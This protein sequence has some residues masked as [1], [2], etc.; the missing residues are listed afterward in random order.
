MCSS[1]L[2]F[3]VSPVFSNCLSLSLTD[4]RPFPP[5]SSAVCTSILVL[6]NMLFKLGSYSLQ[7]LVPPNQCTSPSLLFPF[8]RILQNP[9]PW[10]DLGPPS[11]TVL[12][13]RVT[14]P[15]TTGTVSLLPPKTDLCKV[16]ASPFVPH[17][18]GFLERFSLSPV[19]LRVR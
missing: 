11:Q 3:A 10:S 14:Q 12:S 1:V 17:G 13:T 19:A 18:L 6:C 9:P 2:L 4:A 7:G 5:P 8:G 15:F 16:A